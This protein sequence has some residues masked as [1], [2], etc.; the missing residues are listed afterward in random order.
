MYTVILLEMRCCSA[1][2]AQ[3]NVEAQ[4]ILQVIVLTLYVEWGSVVVVGGGGGARQEKLHCV[5]LLWYS[6]KSANLLQDSSPWLLAFRAA[7]CI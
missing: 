4:E 6:A 1:L 7:T 5:W 3:Y 2:A